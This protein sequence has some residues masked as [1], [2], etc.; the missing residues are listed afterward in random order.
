[1]SENDSPPAQA[2]SAVPA[3]PPVPLT[4]E[5]PAPDP[6]TTG[7]SQEPEDTYVINIFYD[8]VY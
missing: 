3:V 1:M 4:T 8:P 5:G 2:P 6:N 7:G